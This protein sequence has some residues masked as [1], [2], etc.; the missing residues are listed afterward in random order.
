LGGGDSLWKKSIWS[1]HFATQ[2]FFK[3]KRKKELKQNWGGKFYEKR[4]FKKKN[5]NGLK[6]KHVP[7]GRRRA[8]KTWLPK[9]F[10][11]DDF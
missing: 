8:N 10:P 11:S 6:L 9:Y 2:T 5:T 1:R 7:R 3:E 4:L